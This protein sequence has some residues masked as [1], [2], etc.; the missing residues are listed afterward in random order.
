MHPKIS[1]GDLA[2]ADLA[3]HELPLKPLI[4]ETQ[5]YARKIAHR[6]IWSSRRCSPRSNTEPKSAEGK[7]RHP[8][9]RASEV[10]ELRVA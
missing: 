8:S 6:G 3:G 7:V 10:Y 9:S 4:R 1:R 5:P 2:P